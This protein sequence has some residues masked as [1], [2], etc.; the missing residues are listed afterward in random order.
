MLTNL[1]TNLTN[2]EDFVKAL[3]ATK[4]GCISQVNVG[5]LGISI[6]FYSGIHRE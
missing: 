4:N 1:I 3:W 5:W 2:V 6:N